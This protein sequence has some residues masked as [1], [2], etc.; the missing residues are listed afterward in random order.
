MLFI[1]DLKSDDLKGLCDEGLRKH[2]G[3]VF[4]VSDTENDLTIPFFLLIL[5]LQNVSSRL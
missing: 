2:N 5:G 3:S 4:Q 1:A